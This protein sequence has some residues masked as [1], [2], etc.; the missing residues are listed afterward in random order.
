MNV[1]RWQPSKFFVFEL[2]TIYELYNWFVELTP[3]T[4]RALLSFSKGSWLPSILVS[5]LNLELD[6]K[7]NEKYIP[8]EL[9][10]DLIFLAQSLQD[11][12]E[13]SNE[14][15]EIQEIFIFNQQKY[16]DELLDFQT[17]FHPENFNNWTEISRQQF[18]S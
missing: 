13:N 2:C 1:G 9:D 18:K 5:G 6:L 3:L 8:L 16:F 15:F 4:Y 11:L 17:F 12:A 14:N 10:T 7:N